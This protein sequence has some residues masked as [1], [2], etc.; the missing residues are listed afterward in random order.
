[1]NH[2]EFITQS[3]CYPKKRSNSTHVFRSLNVNIWGWER[4]QKMRQIFKRRSY[5]TK[6]V[7]NIIGRLSEKGKCE[8]FKFVPLRMGCY[9]WSGDFG[10]IDTEQHFNRLKWKDGGL[11][12][13][14]CERRAVL[15]MHRVRFNYAHGKSFKKELK[16]LV[17]RQISHWSFWCESFQF[18]F[19][20]WLF[21]ACQWTK[22]NKIKTKHRRNKI[23]QFRDVKTRL[24]RINKR[25]TNQ[26]CTPQ[27]KT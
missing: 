19:V 4:E 27:P 11:D 15:C 24:I 13:G 6:Q 21:G 2:N 12:L 22:W 9:C 25:K 3:F 5:I 20:E 1:M 26:R 16:H 8:C 10:G 23:V 14:I 18:N 17:C 7:C